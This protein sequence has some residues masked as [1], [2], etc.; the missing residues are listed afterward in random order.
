MHCKCAHKAFSSRHCHGYYLKEFVIVI[1]VP[2]FL[3]SIYIFSLSSLPIWMSF[4]TNLCEWYHMWYLHANFPL[5]FSNLVLKWLPFILIRVTNRP[6]KT[7]CGPIGIVYFSLRHFLLIPSL[8]LF[9][10]TPLWSIVQWIMTKI[11]S[12]FFSSPAFNLP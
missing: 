5:I 6:F 1:E 12:L 9:Q 2:I 10:E 7:L 8:C 4:H 3:S 11:F